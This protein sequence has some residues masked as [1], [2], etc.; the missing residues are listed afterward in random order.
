[1]A[2]LLERLEC[3]AG[4]SRLYRSLLVVGSKFYIFEK[5]CILFH[6][7]GDAAIAEAASLVWILECLNS[8]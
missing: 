8:I 4:I 6:L 2:S 1:M 3:V 5:Q 7:L